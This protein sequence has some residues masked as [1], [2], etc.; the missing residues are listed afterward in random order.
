MTR[1]GCFVLHV[2]CDAPA[3]APAPGQSSRDEFTGETRVDA[4]GAARAAGWLLSERGVL[5]AYDRC[6]ACAR[7]AGGLVRPLPAGTI[8]PIRFR[9]SE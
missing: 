5:P 1:V 2:T 4:E 7:A 3:S 8:A 9:P 6:P